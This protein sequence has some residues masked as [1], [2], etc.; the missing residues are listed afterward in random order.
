MAAT[1]LSD[2]FKLL[3]RKASSQVRTGQILI[4]ILTKCLYKDKTAF[5]YKFLAHVTEYRVLCSR[6]VSP[7]AQHSSCPVSGSC[8]ADTQ[9]GRCLCLHV[10]IP[11]CVRG[12]C[13]EKLPP[14]V[15]FC[16]I[17]QAF[18]GNCGCL[19]RLQTL[20]FRGFRSL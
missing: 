5:F 10:Q 17:L 18:P 20:V 16:D 11:L 7:D 8:F 9:S 12:V 19:Y 14:Q 3:R 15:C 2:H 6:M 13:Y 4:F 1:G